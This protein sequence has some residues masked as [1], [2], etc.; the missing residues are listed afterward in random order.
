MFH[1]ISVHASMVVFTRTVEAACRSP[2]NFQ[3]NAFISLHRVLMH[4]EAFGFIS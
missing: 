1:I 2:P 4:V 3:I